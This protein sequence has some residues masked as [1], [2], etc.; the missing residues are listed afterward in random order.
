[1]TIEEF[2]TLLLAHGANP[3]RWPVERRAAAEALLAQNE[4][5]RAL[6]AESERLDA[7]IAAGVA[8]PAAGGALTV[9]IL[10][11]LDAAPPERVFGLGRL[12]AWTGSTAAAALLA[13][14]L[15]GQGIGGLDPSANL[16]ALMT[17]ELTE[18]EAMP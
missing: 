13:G 18:I 7:A 2:E 8:A 16:L 1:M 6:L 12:F 17:G 11:G 10:A 14:F 15:V 9:R 3:A 4:A 5:A